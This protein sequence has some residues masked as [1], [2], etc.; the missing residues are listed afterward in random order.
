M[1]GPVDSVPEAVAAM[2]AIG[3]SLSPSDGVADFNRMYLSVT[4]AVGQAVTSGFFTNSTFLERLDVNFANRYLSAVAAA[5]AC[6]SVP[7]CWDVLWRDRGST[8]RLPLQFAIAGMNAHINHDLV[9]ALIETFDEFGGSPSDDGMH[10]D[11]DRVNAL[12]ASLETGIRRSFEPEAA[13]RLEHE[14]GPVED[15]LS[16]WSIAAARAAAW[17]DARALWHVRN[18]PHLRSE[19]EQRLD[20]A[21]ALAGRCLLLPIQHHHAHAG[22]QP[23][24]TPAPLLAAQLS[25]DL[26]AAQLPAEH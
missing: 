10:E 3:A 1:A 25:A 5:R 20:D 8:D 9:L 17:E 7:Q 18:H 16:K 24:V 21:V 6:T 23:C 11:F 15:C 13:L 12:L 2:T 26:P 19:W 14:L 4:E 22:G